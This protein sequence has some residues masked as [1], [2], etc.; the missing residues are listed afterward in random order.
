MR[1]G[2]VFRGWTEAFWNVSCMGATAVVGI[3]GIL[4]EKRPLYTRPG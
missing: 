4:L 3:F 1:A 2:V